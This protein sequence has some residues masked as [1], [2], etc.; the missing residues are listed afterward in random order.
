MNK[1]GENCLFLVNCAFSP[2]FAAFGT[3]TLELLSGPHSAVETRDLT[4]LGVVAVTFV[5][6]Q[7]EKNGYEGM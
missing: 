2:L 4:N 5:T 1:Y 7:E 3:I 6:S